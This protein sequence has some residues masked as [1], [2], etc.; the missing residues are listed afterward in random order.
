MQYIHVLY[1]YSTTIRHT[2]D[3]K[4]V[5]GDVV[6]MRPFMRPFIH[7]YNGPVC[8]SDSLMPEKFGYYGKQCLCAAN[9][10]QSKSCTR[11]TNIIR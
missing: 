3:L 8:L 11:K 6:R 4:T 10:S 7:S 2:R 9:G 5:E 1:I